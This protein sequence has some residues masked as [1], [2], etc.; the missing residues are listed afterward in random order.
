M[1]CLQEWWKR[2]TLPRAS[3]SSTK[4]SR[5]RRMSALRSLGDKCVST[6]GIHAR[7]TMQLQ[8]R[9][10]SGLVHRLWF[11][12]AVRTGMRGL[13]HPHKYTHLSDR[14]SLFLA[15]IALQSQVRR[16]LQAKFKT[17]IDALDC[18]SCCSDVR[19]CCQ[20]ELAGFGLGQHNPSLGQPTT[21]HTTSHWSL[22]YCV[23]RCPQCVQRMADVRLSLGALTKCSVV[24]R[25]K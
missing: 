11:G 6:Q 17:G 19:H 25:T 3:G 7:V 13:E 9:G 8:S 4:F 1:I 16:K 2:L 18:V 20:C 21:A 23:G 22:R 14:K 5:F 12:R 10:H 24:Q 15:L